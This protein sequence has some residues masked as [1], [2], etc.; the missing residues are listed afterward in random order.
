MPF[1]LPSSDPSLLL[2]KLCSGKTKK[3]TSWDQSNFQAIQ[4]CNF[5]QATE[6]R[7]MHLLSALNAVNQRIVNHSYTGTQNDCSSD[8]IR[9]MVISERLRCY[10]L[11]FRV[12][13]SKKQPFKLAYMNPTFLGSTQFSSIASRDHLHHKLESHLINS[14]VQCMAKDTRNIMYTE[15]IDNVKL[16]SISLRYCCSKF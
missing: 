7:C 9:C 14:S 2:V 12:N 10:M 8:Q 5:R 3:H 6:D 16:L 11:C 15:L 13:W 1:F 4:V